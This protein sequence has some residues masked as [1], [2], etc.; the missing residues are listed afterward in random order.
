MA[1]FCDDPCV[2]LGQNGSFQQRRIFGYDL[3]AGAH[4]EFN[5]SPEE[6]DEGDGKIKRD[7]SPPGQSP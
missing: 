5:V 3:R 2:H 4:S 6:E 7:S 1:D